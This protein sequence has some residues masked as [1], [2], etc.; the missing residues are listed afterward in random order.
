MAAGSSDVAHV[1]VADAA[2]VTQDHGELCEELFAGCDGLEELASLE[3]LAEAAVAAA[4]A[5]EEALTHTPGTHPSVSDC[6]GSVSK[7]ADALQRDDG[8]GVRVGHDEGD[9]E[10][11]PFDFGGD[12][13]PAAYESD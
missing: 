4:A 7:D 8:R 11:D 3:A 10:V 2:A 12:L 9:S 5:C 13:G 1:S 6:Y